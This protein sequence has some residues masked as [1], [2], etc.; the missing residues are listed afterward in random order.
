M[1]IQIPNFHQCK[2]IVSQQRSPHERYAGRLA[3]AGY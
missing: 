3:H 1:T 2:I